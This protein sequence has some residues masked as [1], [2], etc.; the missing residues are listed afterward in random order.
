MIEANIAD[1]EASSDGRENSLPRGSSVVLLI[2]GEGTD[3]RCAVVETREKRGH[4]PPRHLHTREDEVVYVLE[5]EVTFHVGD[6]QLAGTV[7]ACIRLPRGV[8]HT[9]TVNSNEAKLLVMLVPAGL[10][11]Y[12]R[13]MGWSQIESDE[14][15]VERMAA[16]AARYGVEI[17]GPPAGI[18]DVEQRTEAA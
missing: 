10:E 8:E 16:T 1:C 11:G 14:L 4:E 7:G 5:G 13:E 18:T 2:T 6:E 3:G 9:F 17:T 15:A 12:F